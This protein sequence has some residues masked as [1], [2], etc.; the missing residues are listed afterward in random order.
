MCFHEMKGRTWHLKR[1]VRNLVLDQV[2]ER[3]KYFSSHL[4]WRY[5]LL[6]IWTTSQR[7]MRCSICL[8][9]T[10]GKYSSVLMQRS[11]FRCGVCVAR[12]DQL[13]VV[14][15][16]NRTW[17]HGAWRHWVN[18]RRLFYWGALHFLISSRSCKF[19]GSRTP[20][21]TPMVSQGEL[22]WEKSSWRLLSEV[23]VERSCS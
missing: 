16:S 23:S 14:S 18:R 3:S 1:V 9:L 2:E 6:R 15:K 20:W 17:Q 5:D 11:L 12:D 4:W 13:S 21:G 22:I 8:R 7:D 19:F 10:T